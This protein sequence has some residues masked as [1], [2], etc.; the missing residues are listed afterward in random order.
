VLEVINTQLAK[1]L[2]SVC[3]GDSLSYC[4]H[5]LH[6][7]LNWNDTSTAYSGSFW[8]PNSESGL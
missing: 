6:W 1:L 2:T 4:L 7:G 5:C 3:V 8:P